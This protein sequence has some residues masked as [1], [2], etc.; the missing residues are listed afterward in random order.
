MV[1]IDFYGGVDEIGGN[2]ILLGSDSTSIFFDFGMSF[3]KA[4]EYFSE[5]LQPRKGNGIMDFVELGLL[6]K[7]KGIY[8]DDYLKHCGLNSYEK[9]SVDGLLLSHAHMDHSAYIHHLRHD[10][11]LY[12][13]EESQLI[14]KVLEETSSV[15]FGETLKYKK[16]FHFTAK[17]RSD[18]FKRLIGKETLI[19]RNLN[20]VEPYK[21]FEIG[22]LTLKSAPVDHSLPGAS[23]FILENNDETIVYTGDLRF[24]GRKPEITK[25]FVKEAK[26]ANPNVMISE[27]TRIDSSSTETEEDIEIKAKN[28]IADFKGLVIVNF[29]VRDLDRLLTF[30]RV[31]KETERRL[32]VNLKQA[33][34]LKLFSG[35]DYPE[36]DDVDVYIPRRGW[37][38]IDDDSFVCFDGEWLCGSNIDTSHRTSDYKKWEKEFIEGGNAV[39]YRDLQEE[40]E[41]YIFRCDFFELK[42]LID[43]K[44]ENAVYIKSVTEPFDEEMELDERRIN[45]WLGH[46]NLLPVY[47]MHVS[48]H[49]SGPELL[50]MIREI[51]PEVL[52]PIHTT[53]KELFMELEK[54][55]IKVTYP[56][57]STK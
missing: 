30:Y 20:I 38:L 29:P 45:N 51:Q 23:A 33:Y 28:I 41:K 32:V 49:A 27:G 34:M 9:P 18:G 3:N 11:P 8:R 4:N 13:T 7:I 6:P 40:P 37:G 22:D 1:R 50:E 10:I 31:A 55:G 52:Y 14:L 19:E 26:T 57:L 24:H 54:D 15:S 21:N 12:M 35:R 47:K 16:T 2:K 46:F 44:P 48:G 43:V 25:K 56:T 17:K 39:N 42:E 53:H 36:L 5:F